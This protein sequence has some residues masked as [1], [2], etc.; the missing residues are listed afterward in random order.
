[1]PLAP[2]QRTPYIRELRHVQAFHGFDRKENTATRNRAHAAIRLL[3]DNPDHPQRLLLAHHREA[4]IVAGARVAVAV[5]ETR[6]ITRILC[7]RLPLSIT[8]RDGLSD[9][10]RR[11]FW[12]E[13]LGEIIQQDR[14]VRIVAGEKLALQGLERFIL[15]RRRWQSRH[16]SEMRFPVGHDLAH[17]A[18]FRFHLGHIR[19]LRDLGASS[20]V[21]HWRFIRIWRFGVVFLIKPAK[22]LP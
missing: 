8:Q 20:L 9:E 12:I 13:L 4:V 14:L 22:V 16:K 17:Y 2:L 19:K 1:M 5:A 21:K 11:I 15:A 6:L 10:I 7:Q 18:D 3:V